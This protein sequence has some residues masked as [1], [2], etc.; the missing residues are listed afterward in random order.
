MVF[1]EI[2]MIYDIGLI[3]LSVSI[4]VFAVTL[5]VLCK[6]KSVTEVEEKEEEEETVRVAKVSATAYPLT[7]IDVATD[8]F[9]SRRIIG[10]GRLGTVYVAVMRPK[11][12]LVAVKRIHPRLVLNNAGFG[13][14]SILK[15]LSLADH[16]HVVPITGFSE[17]PG[18]RII[19]MEFGGM[20]SLDFYLHQNPDGGALLDWSRRLRIAAG[21]ARGLEY[22][23]KVASPPV[24]HGCV[25]PSNI[26]VDVKFCAR[27]CDYGLHFLASQ[28]R[29]GLVGY[30]DEE[31]WLNKSG[32]S[33][34]CDVFGLGVVLLELLSGRRSDY[35]QENVINIVQW[36]LPLI[37]GMK[38]SEL[39]DPRLAIPF[40]IEP[41]VRLARVALACVG[42]SRPNRPCIAQVATIL[43]N[44]EMDLY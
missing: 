32:A 6:K 16:P 9:N 38:F 31:Y 18:E 4:I 42:N 33:K 27:L 2:A 44:L 29:Q 26:L 22:L 25:K 3:I 12:E 37:K 23:H 13:F 7:E 28:E 11:G 34:E 24:I 43:T 36:A 40:N 41:L 1:G 19:V 5:C 15:Y 30:V 39:F 8:G 35:Y 14:S 20:L 21:A 17:G 10:K